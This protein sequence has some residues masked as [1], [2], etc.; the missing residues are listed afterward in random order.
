MLAMALACLGGCSIG[1]TASTDAREPS[2]RLF[3][4]VGEATSRQTG[5]DRPR[6]PSRKFTIAIHVD[7]EFMRTVGGIDAPVW[8][9]EVAYAVRACSTVLEIEVGLALSLTGTERWTSPDDTPLLSRQL[10]ALRTQARSGSA[11]YVIGIL[12]PRKNWTYLSDDGNPSAGLAEALGRYAVV[13]LEDRVLAWKALRCNLLHEFG[14][15]R[16]AWHVNADDSIMFGAGTWNWTFDAV[17]RRVLECTSGM[18]ATGGVETL[19]DSVVEDLLGLWSADHA[20]DA[21]FT[22]S[23]AYAGIADA[24]IEE[25]AYLNAAEACS[26]AR[27]LF[28]QAG[29]GVVEF[30]H[31]MSV[32]ES[33]SRAVMGDFRGATL[34]LHE[35]LGVLKDRGA[36]ANQVA[37]LHLLLAEFQWRMGYDNLAALTHAR[38]SVLGLVVGNGGQPEKLIAALE[39]RGFLECECGLIEQAV[40]TYARA[41]ELAD[42]VDLN[43][44]ASRLRESLMA[45]E[46]QS[47]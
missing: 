8:R 14:H 23:V 25:G 46:S 1:A 35:A 41:I 37:D 40:A 42:A 47:R 34:A 19:P 22:P 18:S 6:Q 7:E 32:T 20:A 44:V 13:C 27:R 4:Q 39:W 16:G 10:E 45:I 3:G 15:L 12:G 36:T 9:D 24:F 29:G 43:A 11:D 28:L 33:R 30:Y 5:T 38:E 31:S 2:I 17:S 26:M 21:G